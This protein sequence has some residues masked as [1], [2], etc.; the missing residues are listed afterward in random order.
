MYEKKMSVN[1]GAGRCRI[2]CA[3]ERGIEGMCREVGVW[4][5]QA[6]GDTVY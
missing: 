6:I 3:G 1:N 5:M 4:G 2:V